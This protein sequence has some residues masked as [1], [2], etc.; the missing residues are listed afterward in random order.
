MGKIAYVFPGQGA[1]TVGMGKDLYE[2]YASARQI[3]DQADETLGF[4]LSEL[5]FAGDEEELTKTQN[6]Q[7]ALLTMSMACLAAV[8]EEKGEAFPVASYTAG[9]SLGEY[10]ALCASGV[11]DFPTA[12]KLA[13]KR[14]ELMGAAG[15]VRPGAM[16]AVIGAKDEVVEKAC[17]ENG[18]YVA[19]YNCPGQVAIS[20]DADKIVAARKVL[21]KMKDQGVKLVMPLQ[22]SGAFHS[23]LMEP[24]AAGLNQALDQT[25]FANPQ[26]PVIGNTKAQVITTSDGVKE[27]LKNQLCNAVQWTKT[28]QAMIADG[29]DTFIEI[30]SGTVLA[31]LIKRID[32]NVKIINVGDVEAVKNF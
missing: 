24:A 23:P 2:S 9:H 4:S 30:G 5:C 26:I 22:V 10:S 12:L 11:F 1:Q 17:E 21:R 16:A 27:E 14:G 28:V 13:R 25:T 19:N 29:V 6:A 15:D 8:R 18:V 31:G 7:P 20:G 32:S 3:F